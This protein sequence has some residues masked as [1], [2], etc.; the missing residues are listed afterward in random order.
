MPPQVQ[1]KT[2]PTA[3]Y[4]DDK[5]QGHDGE[6]G[7]GSRTSRAS[8][9]QETERTL[10]PPPEMFRPG[11]YGELKLL[12]VETCS[13]N[14]L[15]ALSQVNQDFRRMAL[16]RKYKTV[17]VDETNV[18]T[19]IDEKKLDRISKSMRVREEHF[20]HTKRVFVRVH[21]RPARFLFR[22]LE[23]VKM[24]LVAVVRKIIQQ[25]KTRVE[26]LSVNSLPQLPTCLS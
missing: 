2:A 25:A 5:P 16:I 1:R 6:D 11:Q 20:F 3:G 13:A 22:E 10:I 12:L 17:V 7:T 14:L 8:K 19:Y 26:I 21:P 18:L 9:S 4:D 15:E 24:G 23:L